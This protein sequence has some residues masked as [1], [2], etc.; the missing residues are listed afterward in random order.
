[1]VLRKVDLIHI[2]DCGNVVPYALG[3]GEELQAI[4]T[5]QIFWLMSIGEENL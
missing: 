1:M 5:I 4:G 3:R 2:L